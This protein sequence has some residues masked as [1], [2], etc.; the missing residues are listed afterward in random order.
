MRKT[1]KLTAIT[2]IFA[3][4][5]VLN[6]LNWIKNNYFTAITVSR[7]LACYRFINCLLSRFF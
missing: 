6:Q 1:S 5:I 4:L 3:I 2:V 7:C